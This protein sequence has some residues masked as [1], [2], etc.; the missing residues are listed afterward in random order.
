MPGISIP[1]VSDKYKTNDLVSGLMKVERAPLV[2]EQSSLETYR[3]QANSLRK[4]NQNLTELRESARELFSF[5]NPFNTKN[6]VS[7][8]DAVVSAVADRN[9][10]FQSFQIQV[11]SIATRDRLLSGEI[12]KNMQVPAGRY[13]WTVGEN[14]EISLDWKGGTIGE[15][16]A[17]LNRRGKDYL[18]ASLINLS[19][20]KQ[21]LMLESLKPGDKNI[22]G[23]LGNAHALA[24]SIG[25]IAPAAEFPPAANP[26]P[27]TLP[28]PQ[29]APSPPPQP[30]AAQGA[31][32]MEATEGEFDAVS[33]AGYPAPPQIVQ[34]PPSPEAAPQQLAEQEKN[35]DTLAQE[36]SA[37]GMDRQ[38]SAQDTGGSARDYRPLHPV[39]LAGDA[40][41]SYQG[42]PMTRPANAVNDVVPGVTL[43]LHR[44]SDM[45]VTIDIGRDAVA[46]KSAIITFVG[47]YNQ[48][49]AEINV[50]TQNRQEI[51]T[52]LSYLSPEE[53]EAARKNLGTFQGDFTLNNAK[54][55]LLGIVTGSHRT[56]DGTSLT[57]SNIGISTRAD[58]S[59]GYAES[60]LRGYLEINEK[61]LD[62]AIA[63][64]LGG[65]KDLFGY[66]SDGD[67]IIDSGIAFQM[68]RDIQP[69][70]QRNG[71][72]SDR[73]N[74][75]NARIT[76][77]ETKIRQMET[78]LDRRE[79]ELRRTYGQMEA[80]L[81]SLEGQSSALD[82]F[83]RRTQSE[84]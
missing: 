15:F 30:V 79:A 7:S 49:V 6:A 3:S 57:L 60:K 34:V 9:A 51:I 52:E 68:N 25:M 27:E 22:L 72:I 44:G 1:G 82:N 24:E 5:E 81:N 29:A 38:S 43:N 42:I 46:A 77:S 66:D 65:I 10:D 28:A 17:S 45:P 11:E 58:S 73:V 31:A 20:G 56:G 32:D 50:L 35:T 84:R 47:K 83:T 14:R 63:G 71:I 18:N 19:P 37:Q 62:A 69:Y 53:Q 76:G 67:L 70:T 55:A 23:F 33:A 12:E 16:V 39:E 21:S 2:K 64:N 40:K 13:G 36:A 48:T 4:V 41:L 80:T 54:S 61:K 26:P 75:I 59:T 74:N 78:R 8:N